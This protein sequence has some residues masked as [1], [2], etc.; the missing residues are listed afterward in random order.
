M[1]FRFYGAPKNRNPS[2]KLAEFLSTKD[3]LFDIFQSD[4]VQRSKSEKQYILKMKEDDYKFYN[5]QKTVRKMTCENKVVKKDAIDTK[6]ESSLKRSA[7][8]EKRLQAHT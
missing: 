4:D 3:D 5:D 7:S 2:P 8:Y 6:F 1:V